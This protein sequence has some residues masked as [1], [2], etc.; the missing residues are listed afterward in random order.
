MTHPHDP[1][2]VTVTG[3]Y[4]DRG[5]CRQIFVYLNYDT[6]T[7]ADVADAVRA[8]FKPDVTERDLGLG[9]TRAFPFVGLNGHAVAPL[10][11]RAEGEWFNK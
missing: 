3:H 5:E 8:V 10:P 11:T 9:Q 2:K 6:V 4:D 1:D 7:A